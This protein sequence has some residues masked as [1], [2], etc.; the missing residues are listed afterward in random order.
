M[1]SNEKMADASKNDIHAIFKRLRSIPTNK[2]CFDCNSKNSTWA[3]VTYG[4]F[5]CIDCSAVHRS[6]GVHVTF[7]RSTQLDSWAWPQLRAM[8]VGGNAN[9]TVFFRQHGTS[10]AD[11]NKKYHSRAAQLYKEKIK[12][13]AAAAMR[14]YG[15]DS[16]HIGDHAVSSPETKEVD[17]FK[18]HHDD[19]AFSTPAANYPSEQNMN[20]SFTPQEEEV[21][22]QAVPIKN[23]QEAEGEVDTREPSVDHVLGTSPSQLMAKVEP[24]KSTIGQRK[25]M[26]KKGLGAKKKLG[27]QKVTTNFADIESAAHQADLMKKETV[28]KTKK[29]KEEE[30]SSMAS[31]RLAYQDM[32]VERKR[33]ED[34]MKTANPQKAEQMERLGMGFGGRSAVSH[35]AMSDM[36]T[37]K[38]DTPS[39]STKTQRSSSRDFFD[40]FATG[41]SGFSSRSKDT[42]YGSRKD[43]DDENERDD[44][45]TVD[46]PKQSEGYDSIKPL[47]DRMSASKKKP[48]ETTSTSTEAQKRFSNA[49]SIS[50]D[51]YFGKSE[52]DDTTR[53]NLDRMS[54]KSS[55]SSSEL[56]GDQ[57]TAGASYNAGPDMSA[58]KDGMKDSVTQVAGRL[59]RMANGIVNTIQDRYGY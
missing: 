51:A 27:A 38:Q 13:L 12:T 41:S 45:D 31:M 56:Y 59:S 21:K 16:V 24:R 25:P 5:L 14:K 32:S 18:E 8:Q 33:Q 49:K 2:S 15:T 58:I 19:L 20:L 36:Q 53:A 7:I 48:Y 3:S 11:A 6:L 10:T 1:S 4:V 50:S 17:F 46:K 23:G 28:I 40:D 54:G 35:S 55:I 57:T 43:R 44:W 9:A 52:M 22:V 47:E 30:E 26:Q 34:R 29:T 39:S 37:I 42:S